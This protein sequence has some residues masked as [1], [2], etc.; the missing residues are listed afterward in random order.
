MSSSDPPVIAFELGLGEFR[1]V[2][3]EAVY[4]IKVRPDLVEAA[5]AGETQASGRP[6]GQSGVFYQKISEELFEKVGQ[7][8]RKLSV[9]VEELPGQLAEPDF[10]AT[11]QQ[12]ENAKGQLEEIVRL[13]EKASMTIMDKADQIQVDMDQLKSQLDILKSL[14]LMTAGEES[15]RPEGPPADARPQIAIRDSPSLS[16]DFFDKLAELKTFVETLLSLAESEPPAEAPAAAAPDSEP[17][18]GSSA[19]AAPESEPPAGGSTPA[20]PTVSFNVDV[21]FQ[22][23]YELCTNEA[24]KDH[25]RQMRE[26]SS[27]AFNE[28]EIAA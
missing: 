11:D 25:I 14:D 19:P 27:S 23:L 9:S 26:E 18:A 16:P 12:L 6:T 3:P 24:V 20:A 2:T 15:A 8:A 17:P 5:R 7:L 22:T 1:I 21:V 13:T 28:P 10:G 4:E